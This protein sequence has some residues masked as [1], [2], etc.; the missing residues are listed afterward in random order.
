MEIEEKQSIESAIDANKCL[1]TM[2]VP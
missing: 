1:K 2:L